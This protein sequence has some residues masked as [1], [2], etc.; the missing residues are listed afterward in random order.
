MTKYIVRR[1][2]WLPVVIVVIGFITFTLGLYGP[3]DPIQMWLG[4]RNNPE[5]VARLRR[6]RGLDRPLLVQYTDYMSKA[7]RGDFGE[8][9][10][11]RG[12]PV[13]TL[14]GKGLWI[15]IQ[16]NLASLLIGLLVGVPLGILAALKRNTILDYLISSAVVFGISLPIFLIGPILLF[17]FA[18]W[19]R[20]VPP[21]GWDGL[22]SRS[23]LLPLFVLSLGPIAVFARQTRANL[24]EVLEAD[25][26]R[27]A[28]A[29][30]LPESLVITRHAL[31]N[32]FLPLFT[33][34][35]LMLGDLVSGAVITETLFGIPGIGRLSYDAL[36]GRDYPIIMAVTLLG[37]TSYT[38]ANLLVDIGYTLIDP[39]IRYTE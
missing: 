2:L 9:L 8:S 28:R 4:Q 10:R 12:Q 31:R 16:L 3:G 37:A 19:L 14:L 6:E 34:L 5:A 30:G 1:L 18:W 21:G 22:F 7:L 25:Y 36:F 11:Y 20:I 39:R 13:S 33:I 23:A 26:I 38:I 17:I 27:M 35:G 29:K 15:T 24:S 32:A